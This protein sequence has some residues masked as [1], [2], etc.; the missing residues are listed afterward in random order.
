MFGLHAMRDERTR[1]VLLCPDE[2]VSCYLS[3]RIEASRLAEL[4]PKI[5]IKLHI[6]IVNSYL[7]ILNTIYFY[8]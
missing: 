3:R 7:F 6:Y 1:F 5:R 8:S 2:D 4:S